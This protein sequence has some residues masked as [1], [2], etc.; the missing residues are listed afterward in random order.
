MVS[1]GEGVIIAGANDVS[2]GF[3]FFA[4]RG[5]KTGMYQFDSGKVIRKPG[6]FR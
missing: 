4:W 3:E 6:N 1:D 2:G 5:K